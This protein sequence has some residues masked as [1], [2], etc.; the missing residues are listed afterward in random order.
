LSGIAILRKPRILV[1]QTFGFRYESMAISPSILVEAA[2]L[3]DWNMEAPS[4]KCASDPLASV[5]LNDQ[6]FTII[7]GIATAIDRESSDGS[8]KAPLIRA[9]LETI[10]RRPDGIQI[11]V[12]IIQLLQQV[13]FGWRE[14][15]F[16][17]MNDII[18]RLYHDWAP[19]LA[20]EDP[21]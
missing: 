4:F 9:V 7:G 16:A 2:R 20:P 13:P 11:F 18:G 8:K 6:F 19:P 17:A 15:W 10:S 12:L 5:P 14:E 3:A 1:Y 21:A